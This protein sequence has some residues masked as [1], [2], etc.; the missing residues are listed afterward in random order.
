MLVVF[1]RVTV[2]NTEC[3]CVYHTP[4]PFRRSRFGITAGV[5]ESGRSPS[6]TSTIKSAG[7][8][9]TAASSERHTSKDRIV[10][11]MSVAVCHHF[12][13]AAPAPN[14]RQVSGPATSTRFVFHV[15]S[16]G[17]RYSLGL[18]REGQRMAM[19]LTAKTYWLFLSQVR[20]RAIRS[21]PEFEV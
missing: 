15:W 6:M 4:A 20:K 16:D 18:N 14:D 2:G 17:L 5:M 12:P 3:E 11:F 21:L 9:L 19:S 8:S 13:T 10:V 1:T 7:R